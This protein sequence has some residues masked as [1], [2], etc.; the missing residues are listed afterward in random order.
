MLPKEYTQFPDCAIE[1]LRQTRWDPDATR[2]WDLMADGFFWSDEG[3]R[4]TLDKCGPEVV[5]PFRCVF[6]YRASLVRS[7][8]RAELQ[9][10]WDQLIAQC[11]TWPGFRPERADACLAEELEV[12]CDEGNQHVERVFEIFDR[13]QRI[14]EIREKRKRT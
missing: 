11:P 7:A 10:S 8:P 6:A 1:V 3:F 5:N 9:E 2:E 12:R 4:E 14:H 13:A